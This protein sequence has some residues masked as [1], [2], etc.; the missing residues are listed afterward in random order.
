MIK[1]NFC[2]AY[3]ALVYQCRN[4]KFEPLPNRDFQCKITRHGVFYRHLLSRY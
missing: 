3:A 2:S 4:D 1:V